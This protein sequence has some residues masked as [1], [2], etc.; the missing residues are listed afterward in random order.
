MTVFE[1]LK[2]SNAAT[3]AARLRVLGDREPTLVG[4]LEALLEADAQLESP[5]EQS[6]ALEGFADTVTPD[7]RASTPAALSPDPLPAP[8][9][10][11]LGLYRLT[12][13]LGRGGMGCVYIGQHV[14]LVRPVAIKVLD[15][16]LAD[17]AD[18]VS[19]FL[20]EAKIVNAVRHPNIV[21]IF[22][23]IDQP[24]PRRVALVMELLQGRTLSRVLARRA[25]STEEAVHA[26]LQLSEALSAVHALG[27]VHRD[28]K[29][30]NVMVVGPL[31]ASKDPLLGAGDPA[32]SIKLLD[33][34]IAKVAD[35]LAVHRTATGAVLGTPAYMA[36]E[37]F[38]AEPPTPATDVYALGELLFEMLTA[39][40]LFADQGLPMIREK[41]NGVRSPPSLPRTVVHERILRGL[42]FDC[43]QV[44]P[45]H[46]PTVEHIR[47]TL[48]PLRPAH[49][50]SRLVPSRRGRPPR[51]SSP[52]LGPRTGLRWGGW[53]A[54]ML[55]AV[56]GTLVVGLGFLRLTP[57][58]YSGG[59][60]DDAVRGG[61]TNATN[62]GDTTSSGSETDAPIDW[63]NRITRGYRGWP[64]DEVLARAGGIEEFIESYREPVEPIS[65]SEIE[66]PQVELPAIIYGDEPSNLPHTATG[67]MGRTDV[68]RMDPAWPENP[69]SGATSLR[70][71]YT[72]SEGWAGVTWTD[73]PFDW[74][75][76]PG[77]RAFHGARRL[78][79]WARGSRPGQSVRLGYGLILRDQA[80][81]DTA[82]K[83]IAV[84]LREE[85]TQYVIDLE[86]AN[87]DRLKCVFYFSVPAEGQ[88]I[89]FFL[90]D[91]RI[92]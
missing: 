77:G 10:E 41:M 91:I 39:R 58:T 54:L 72:E 81:H 82:R 55:A 52:S 53:A 15:P 48:S 4:L 59:R 17:D 33:F 42:I 23:F 60:P 16:P 13:V 87:L 18:Y 65:V 3:R 79:V 31:S 1:E 92:E 68:L 67:F 80:F 66:V 43:L 90:D 38:S 35:P 24:W 29:P 2:A 25:L 62:A 34:G 57:G 50:V 22:D 37:Q 9:G 46:R 26:T 70:I 73:P 30:D 78:S 20:H 51:S 63:M 85:W 44:E 12:A 45:R 88:P 84:Q 32:V 19:R 74:G 8:L 5:L 89:E 36:P 61:P 47:E 75:R 86:G 64:V 56:A 28:L 27:V 71:T 21:D 76:R 14:D 7:R 6:A 83:E 69:H 49:T 11:T 40:P